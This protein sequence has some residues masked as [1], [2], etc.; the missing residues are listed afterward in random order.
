M[1]LCENCQLKIV[2]ILGIVS[3]LGVMLLKFV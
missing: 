2:H 1:K 3:A